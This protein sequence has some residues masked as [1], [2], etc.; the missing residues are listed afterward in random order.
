M[1]IQGWV[2]GEGSK[3]LPRRLA[4]CPFIARLVL[5]CDAHFAVTRNAAIDLFKVLLPGFLFQSSP[6]EEGDFLLGDPLCG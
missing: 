4:D 3:S 1:T 5:Q 2:R 6:V